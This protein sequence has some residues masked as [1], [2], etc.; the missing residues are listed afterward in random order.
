MH[1]CGL[2]AIIIL[3]GTAA[4]GYF[5]GSANATDSWKFASACAVPEI[6]DNT[7]ITRATRHIQYVFIGQTEIQPYLNNSPQLPR[8]TTC[9]FWNSVLYLGTRRYRSSADQLTLSIK[10]RRVF[11]IYGL[12]NL[13]QSGLRYGAVFNKDFRVWK[14]INCG[15]KPSILDWHIERKGS[16]ARFVESERLDQVSRLNRSDPR[17]MRYF[18]FAS[19]GRSLRPRR[20]QCTPEYNQAN[21]AD[22]RRNG[23][24]NV[25]PF[26]DFKLSFKQALLADTPLIF[27]GSHINYRGIRRNRTSLILFGW[28]MM[29]CGFV[30]LLLFIVPFL[31][32]G[33]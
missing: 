17:S 31:A 13:I 15:R 2:I 12:G 26:R 29:F 24:N 4:V 5:K 30:G 23:S 27:V 20:I 9:T 10:P 16:S 22:S 19:R 14:N 25:R 21:D 11:A 28:L 32:Q 7:V 8:D 6:F 18:Q 33:I 1:F 3:V